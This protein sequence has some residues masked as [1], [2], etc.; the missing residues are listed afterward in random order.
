MIDGEKVYS[1][2]LKLM[3]T[4]IFSDAVSYT[5]DKQLQYTVDDISL[6]SQDRTSMVSAPTVSHSI[7][8]STSLIWNSVKEA[9]NKS[10]PSKIYDIE[11]H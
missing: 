2:S 7:I 11:N 4:K 1:R 9:E 10:F 3:R 5:L 8:Y 6:T